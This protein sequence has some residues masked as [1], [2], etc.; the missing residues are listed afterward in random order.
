[1]CE[2]DE[3]LVIEEDQALYERVTVS[4]PRTSSSPPE[5]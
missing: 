4:S 5:D 1:L 3:V 2:D